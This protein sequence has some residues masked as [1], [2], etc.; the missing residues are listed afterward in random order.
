MAGCRR[1][2]HREHLLAFLFGRLLKGP[3]RSRPRPQLHIHVLVE[4]QSDS[5]AQF[6]R[7]N[8]DVGTATCCPPLL[9][10]ASEADS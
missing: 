3:L 8:R 4:S 10:S 6:S 7:W 1:R 9:I 5:H 2:V